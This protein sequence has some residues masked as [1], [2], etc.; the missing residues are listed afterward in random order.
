MLHEVA[1]ALAELPRHAE[2][3]GVGNVHDRRTG[4]DDGLEHAG[5]V[6]VRGA[7]G[8]LGI[9][10][11]IVD[12]LAGMTY[13]GNALIDGL[14]ERHA[15]ELVT[16]MLGRDANARV[17]TRACGNL[18]RLG[19][20]IDIMLDGTR[21]ASD[22]ALVTAGNGDILDG[23]EVTGARHGKA[24]LND[25]DIETKKLSRNDELLLGVHACSW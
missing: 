13:G 7:S 15:L 5:Q 3:R 19:A 18:E 2:A 6:L 23:L 20:H 1:D 22:D 12:V 11:D 24:R 8:I 10:L 21:E 17:D 14:V 25:V 9:E 4:L 16:K